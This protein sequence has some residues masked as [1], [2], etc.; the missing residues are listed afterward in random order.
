MEK[1]YYRIAYWNTTEKELHL[2]IDV[3]LCYTGHADKVSK[4]IEGFIVEH[5]GRVISGYIESWV[6]D[7]F[8]H[9][10]N[11]EIIQ[12]TVSSVDHK[13]SF[14]STTINSID[15]EDGNVE[16]ILRKYKPEVT[17]KRT[18]TIDT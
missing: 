8:L 13:W 15:D 18:V 17:I 2:I 12:E 4:L 11:Y 7:G 5:V 3:D 10:A 14:E 16:I 1:E 6:N 9:D